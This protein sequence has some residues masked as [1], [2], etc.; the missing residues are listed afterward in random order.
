[1]DEVWKDVPRW[2]GYQ[3][4]NHGEI[5]SFRN[6]RGGLKSIPSTLKPEK[7]RGQVRVTLCV[8]MVKRRVSIAHLVL[9]AF[10]SERPKGLVCCH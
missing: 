8:N 2:E 3:V 9:E 6:T 4:S 1:M 10:A 7:S 5:R